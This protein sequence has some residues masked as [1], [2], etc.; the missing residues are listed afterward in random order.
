MSGILGGKAN[1]TRSISWE[2]QEARRKVF[3]RGP[4]KDL[5]KSNY[6]H[7]LSAASR[8]DGGSF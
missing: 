3:I 8:F 1:T 2:T 5:I 7:Q 4:S 6:G